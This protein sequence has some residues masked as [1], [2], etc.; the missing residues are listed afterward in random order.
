[1]P[2]PTPDA[3]AG[4]DT[5]DALRAQGWPARDPVRFR[6]VEALARRASAQAGAARAAIDARLAALLQGLGEPAVKGEGGPLPAAPLVAQRGRLAALV[7]DA[8]RQKPQPVLDMVAKPRDAAPA[9]A[10]TSAAAAR[11]V[12][13]P[14]PAD[15]TLEFFKRTWSRLSAEQRLAQSRATLPDNAGPLNSHHLVHRALT[16]MQGLSPAYLEHFVGYVDALQWLEQASEA[17]ADARAGAP[18]RG[19]ALRR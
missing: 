15:R 1:M 12:P 13:L 2:E 8:A 16:L 18:S 7:A 19:A 11:P 5:L 3:P 6:L 17:A 4:A 10:S 14:M 9:A